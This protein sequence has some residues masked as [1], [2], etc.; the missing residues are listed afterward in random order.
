MG[1]WVKQTLWMGVWVQMRPIVQVMLALALLWTG[2]PARAQ[3]PGGAP[4]PGVVPTPGVA[5]TGMA[6]P[7][8]RAITPNS[9]DEIAYIDFDGYIRTYDPD[10]LDIQWISPSGWW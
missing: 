10:Q 8:P 3:T 1:E 9:N 7:S 4:T 6:T 5:P 2:A